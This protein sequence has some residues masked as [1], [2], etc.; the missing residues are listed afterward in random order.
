MNT[1]RAVSLA[2]AFA[3]YQDMA[4][5]CRGGYIPTLTHN[6]TDELDI[7]RAKTVLKAKLQADG[8]EVHGNA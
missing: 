6:A 7:R 1:Q 8:F 5:A 3:S 2:T 4:T